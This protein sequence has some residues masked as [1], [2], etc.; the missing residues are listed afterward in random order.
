MADTLEATELSRRIFLQMFFGLARR[1]T[2]QDVPGAG[3]ITYDSPVLTPVGR[4]FQQ[5]YHPVG[6]PPPLDLSTWTLAVDGLVRT[7]LSLTYQALRALPARGEMRTL[8]CIG[9]PPGGDQIGNAVWRG[10]D[11][12]ALLRQAGVSPAAT[13]IRFEGADGYSTSVPLDRALGRGVLLA[14]EMNGALLPPAHGFPLRALVPGLYG[15]KSSKWLTRIT[16]IDHDFQGF[17]ESSPRNWSDAAVVKTASHITLPLSYSEVMAGEPVAIQGIA[18]AGGR[19][20]TGVALSVDGGDWVPAALRRPDSPLAWTQWYTLW[21]PPAPGE[22]AISVRA[23]DETGFTQ[24]RRAGHLSDAYPDGSDAIH[25]IV[26][27]AV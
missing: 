8:L 17:W 18:F 16:L 7:P 19:R 23:T 2:G 14:Y 5:A 22:Y 27:R 9:N 15:S 26:L 1:H 21:K 6:G 4:F 24:S 3:Q 20:I 25:S 11:L 12:D 10:V 13:R